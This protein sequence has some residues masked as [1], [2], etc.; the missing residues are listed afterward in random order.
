MMGIIIFSCFL[1]G[2]S[3][4]RDP[5]VMSETVTKGSNVETTLDDKDPINMA[6]GEYYFTLPMF[7]LDGPLPLN[8]SL[9]YATQVDSKRDGEDGFPNLPFSSNHGRYLVN[10]GTEL[11]VETGMGREIGF[12]EDTVIGNWKAGDQERIRYQLKTTTDYFYMLDPSKN[13]LFTYEKRDDVIGY[14]EGKLVR[15]ED[16]NGNALT[17]TKSGSNDVISDGLGRQ[18]TLTR[19]AVSGKSYLTEVKD[20]QNRSYTFTYESSPADN[21]GKYTLRS[22]TDPLGNTTAF[23][24]GGDNL[25]T[26]KRQPE[27]NAPYE[28][29][30][31][32]V[33]RKG[34]VATQKDAYN[35][36]A[37]VTT[38]NYDPYNDPISK[39]DMTYPDNS[40]RNF[41]HDHDAK[42][43][44]SLKD[45]TGKMA[46]FT[47]VPSYKDTVNTIQDRI[48]DQMN[49][50]FHEYSGKIQSFTNALG[51]KTTFTYG[52]QSQTFTNPVN[53]EEVTFTFY[54]L[55]RVDHP[56]SKNEQFIYDG[57]GNITSYTD[58]AGQVWSYT[59]NSRGQTLTSTNPAGGVVT[60]TYNSDGTLASSKD[61]D[62]GTTT[63]GYDDYK[64]LNLIT[65]P[66]GKTMQIAYDLMDRTTAITDENNHTTTYA[67]DKN[68]NLNSVTDPKGNQTEYGYDLMDRLNK[69][70]DR[71]GKITSLAYNNM[72][73]LS[74]FTDPNSITRSLAYNSR[75]WITGLTKGGKTWTYGYDDEGLIAST[76]S[77]SNKSYTYQTNKLGHS[78]G[79]VN[80]LNQTAGFTRD[81][82]ERVTGVTDPLDRTRTYAYDSRGYLSSVTLPAAGTASFTRNNLGILTKITDQRGNSWNLDYT[83]MG[84][85]SLSRDPLNNTWNYSYDNLGRL[86]TV[87]FPGG[88]TLTRTY[89]GVG[90][91]TRLQGEG[92]DITFTY[93]DLNMLS[94]ST[95]ISFSRDGEGRI[96]SSDNAGKIFGAAYDDGGR[97]KTATYNNGLFSVTYAY[98]AETG[99]L[100]GVTDSLT[101]AEV[102]F[103]YD[104]DQR[105]SGINRKNGVNATFT[106][107]D[108][109]RLTRIQDG[110]IID[111][112]YT[113]NAAADITGVNMT[114]PLDPT[115]AFS[116]E[117]TSLAYDAASQA[118][119]SGYAYDAQGRQTAAPGMT[120]QWNSLARLTGI[121]NTA[122]TYNGLGELRTRQEG[123]TTISYYYNY[124]LDNNPLVAEKNDNT[125]QFARY[126]IW[127]PEGRLLYMIDA[128]DGN[129]V[130]YYHFDRTGS[131]LAL[132]NAA[133]SVADSYAYNPVGKLLQ[134][135]GSSV[136]PF[137]FVGQWGVRQEGG[138]GLYQMQVRYYNANTGGFLSREPLW[139]LI[140][141]PRQVNPYQY[142]LNNPIGQIDLTGE[143][144]ETV[145]VKL[146]GQVNFWSDAVRSAIAT[147][148]IKLRE[149]CPDAYGVYDG[150]VDGPQQLAEGRESEG[151]P[152][153]TPGKADYTVIVTQNGDEFVAR[154]KNNKYRWQQGNFVINQKQL[155]AGQPATGEKNK[156]GVSRNSQL[157]NSAL[158]NF[159]RNVALEVRNMLQKNTGCRETV[160]KV[161]ERDPVAD[162]L[163]AW[164][165]SI[166]QKAILLQGLENAK[167][168]ARVGNQ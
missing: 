36:T 99:L 9:Y 68:G 26:K 125:G 67:Y 73:Q 150:S 48:G 139:P 97:L 60:N 101:N 127:T 140:N 32:N 133:G 145:D 56:D 119:S 158:R 138:N 72:E 3:Q 69:I 79:V 110:S 122:L 155:D 123:G 10:Y 112:K 159:S 31:Q 115:S 142:A 103:I 89:D 43:M 81:S 6:T 141:D 88:E 164:V 80:P 51:N 70:T 162:G 20:Q 75:G 47:A 35:N 128:A 157:Y 59:Y 4:A 39:F 82:M 77:P 71:T 130:Y 49:I 44:S 131:T 78:T 85:L 143:A 13:L 134:H 107:D 27:G 55:A 151:K 28:M 166:F 167:T 64:R 24:Y 161:V 93:D 92:M 111:L 37:T 148:L 54:P 163:D 29:T 41:T 116:Q 15:I 45:Q 118:S 84:R 154:V 94:G 38:V 18:F 42:V 74:S 52:E 120:F 50:E 25:I 121:G 87:T 61:S 156:Y 83:N 62:T 66:D 106:Y 153:L 34:I 100:S 58:Q 117:D 147:E 23:T 7:S 21:T 135:N 102:S 152:P 129:K 30:Y 104:N 136:Q 96:T 146:E 1:I 12:F 165:R 5:V 17:Y 168:R 40:T 90:N 65:R 95:N 19:T 16:R 137:T 132:T 33:A 63:Y 2:V 57:E 86:Q 53:N 113:V 109:N 114:A 160:K 98:S 126:Y 105:L 108:A 22:I 46:S 11:F 144:P 14:P 76:T 149:E 124:A 91:V 8:F